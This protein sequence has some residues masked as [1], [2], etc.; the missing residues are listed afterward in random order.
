MPDDYEGAARRHMEDAV[1]LEAGG[2]LDNAGHLVGFAAECAIKWRIENL[3]PSA[4]AVH[5]HFPDLLHAARKQLGPRSNYT[6]MY[7][8]LKGDI[9]K[10]WSVNRRYEATGHTTAE[11][12]AAWIQ[13][14]KRLF[15]AAGLKGSR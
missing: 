13:T 6:G 15:A 7:D 1:T 14:T 12:V 2:R 11:E 5:G 4:T 10:G 3:R 8:L 9:F